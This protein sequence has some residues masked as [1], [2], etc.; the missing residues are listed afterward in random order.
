[1]IVNIKLKGVDD[2]NRPVFK[3]VD[4]NHYYG[5]VTTLFGWDN[6]RQEIID[7]FKANIDELEYFGVHF[8]CEP[9]GGINKNII[10]N[11]VE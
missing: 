10:L 7:Y 1:M 5:S 4:S 3:D 11:I 9:N 6:P 8:G 2:W